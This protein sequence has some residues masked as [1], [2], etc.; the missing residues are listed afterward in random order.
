[1]FIHFANLHIICSCTDL[2]NEIP[3]YIEHCDS[4]SDVIKDKSKIIQAVRQMRYEAV[5]WIKYSF[6]SL[7]IGQEN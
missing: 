1:M 4:D 6:A 2:P 3:V 7:G 5:K